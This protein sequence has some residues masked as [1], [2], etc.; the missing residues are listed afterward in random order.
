MDPFLDSFCAQ[1]WSKKWLKI[2]TFDTFLGPLLASCPRFW[3]SP[4]G[5]NDP[6]LDPFLT[7]FFTLFP[8]YIVYA[9]LNNHHPKID[10]LK[11]WSFW[12][13]MTL[14]NPESEGPEIL[15]PAKN[16]IFHDRQ[17]WQKWKK[18]KKREKMTFFERQNRKKSLLNRK[19]PLFSLFSLLPILLRSRTY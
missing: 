15:D 19:N 13:L 11:R 1:K 18:P 3:G 2:P 4:S 14:G 17:F 9:R 6:L 12:D 8:K 16:M 5:P 7:P 10:P